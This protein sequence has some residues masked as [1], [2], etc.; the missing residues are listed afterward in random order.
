[1][2]PDIHTST[3]AKPDLKGDSLSDPTQPEQNTR[4]IILAVATML[5]LASLDQTIVS[6]AL[7]TIVADLGGLDHLSWVVTSYLLTST[8][9]APL[10][11]KLGDLY[12]RKLMM[13]IS[14]TI[15]L[16]GSALA[17]L[18]QSMWFLIAARAVQGIGGGGLFVLS[19]TVIADVIPP[20]ERSKIQGVFGGVF[21][22]S[23]IA[24]PLAGGFFVDNLTWHWIFYINLPIGL[25]ALAIFAM[26][27][28][29]RGV[30]KKH[31]LDITGALLL[32]VALSSVVLFTSLGGRSFAWG[33]PFIL[34]L[35]ASALVSTIAFFLVERRAEEPILPPSLFRINTFVVMS[36]IGALVGAAMFGAITFLPLYLQVAKGIS[37]TASGLQ[38]MPLMMGILIGS[39][40]SGNIMS[41]TGRYRV[42][43][44]IGALI[45]ALGM[46][47]LTTLAP[48]TPVWTVMLMMLVV[49]IG[50]GPTMSVGTTAIQNAAPMAILGAATAG[51]TLFRQIGGSVGVAVFGALFANQL[52]AK[53]GIALPAGAEP[54]SMNAASIAALPDGIRDQVVTGF[55]EALHPIFM[56]GAA[57]GLLA[58]L[59][60]FFLEEIPLRTRMELDR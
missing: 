3:D 23:S 15:F 45:L 16:L 27:F 5:L 21:G 26:A 52:S 28:K 51:F 2:T 53:L 30:R 42:L 29:P 17:G 8:V 6:T 59:L 34:M 22:L 58:C 25:L 41:I 9:A 46:G 31:P 4:L 33:S 24:G 55:T 54:G 13:Q 18:S 10:Y 44:R 36:G 47:W 19:L 39:I 50:M 56:I 57:A 38:M 43:P 48:D 37:P 60:T 40:G 7:P 49:G 1:M 35:I 20:R 32:T 11:G 14:V 12:G